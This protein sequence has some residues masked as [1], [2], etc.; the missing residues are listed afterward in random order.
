MLDSGE[1]LIGMITIMI[2][3][4]GGPWLRRAC[5][6]IDTDERWRIG[7]SARRPR[8]TLRRS[9][10]RRESCVHHRISTSQPL[11][12]HSNQCVFVRRGS[13]QAIVASCFLLAS[14]IEETLCPLRDILVGLRQMLGPSFAAVLPKRKAGRK[15]PASDEDLL[16]SIRQHEVHTPTLECR[17][18]CN[19]GCGGPIG[20]SISCC[21]WA[22][23]S[24]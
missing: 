2:V 9:I 5:C 23:M 14:K 11:L 10:S 22:S 6:S 8:S 15:T 13:K 12:T 7:A 16:L 19:D 3:G 1:S 21:V 20:R 24:R 18:Q 4:R 17:W